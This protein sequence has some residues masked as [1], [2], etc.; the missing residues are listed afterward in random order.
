MREERRTEE[1][2]LKA[3]MQERGSIGMEDEVVYKWYEATMSGLS[4]SH[5]ASY[6]ASSQTARHRK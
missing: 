3:A 1:S 4:A 5:F 6:F 2:G